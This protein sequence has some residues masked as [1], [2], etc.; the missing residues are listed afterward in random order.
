M[1]IKQDFLPGCPS[2]C[3]SLSPARCQKFPKG[4]WFRCEASRRVTLCEKETLSL[5]ERQ[6]RFS[7]VEVSS[8]WGVSPEGNQ[9]G[10]VLRASISASDEQSPCRGGLRGELATAQGRE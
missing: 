2:V 9:T 7:W 8:S 10:G 3:L 5:P 6:P 1:M 4:G